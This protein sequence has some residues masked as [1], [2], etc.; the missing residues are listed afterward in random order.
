MSEISAEERL[1]PIMLNRDNAYI[2]WRVVEPHEQQ[3]QTNH[4]QTLARLA[5]RGGLDPV[6]LA[7][8]L[9]DLP[10]SWVMA[11]SAA[12]RQAWLIIVRHIEQAAAAKARAEER[13][14]LAKSFE[15][16]QPALFGNEIAAAIRTR[17]DD[18]EK[19]A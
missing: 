11:H 4:G 9:Q 14:R 3:A 10:F 6:E 13:E 2:P 1:F 15:N 12:V 7:A 17:T 8:V 5:E 19:A 16:R 18:P